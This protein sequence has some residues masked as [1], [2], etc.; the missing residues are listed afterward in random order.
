MAVQDRYLRIVW[1]D[2]N[3]NS[4]F[5]PD[6]A[7]TCWSLV[8]T[9]PWL[10]TTTPT[11]RWWVHKIRWDFCS[12]KILGGNERGLCLCRD[13][14]PAVHHPQKAHRARGPLWWGRSSVLC[15]FCHF[16]LPLCLGVH[17][18]FPGFVLSSFINIKS[19]GVGQAEK[20]ACLHHIFCWFFAQSFRSIL[21]SCESTS[22]RCWRSWRSL[23]P[24]SW[25][26]WEIPLT[27]AHCM[28]LF[29]ARWYER[30]HWLVKF[31]RPLHSKV[32]SY[33]TWQTIA[34]IL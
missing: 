19:T 10:W 20:V 18:L 27:T 9:T 26:D 15:C 28:G 32:I 29:T 30:L 1:F 25:A 17:P 3:L 5:N 13:G 8:G 14:G 7:S 31:W 24:R 23:M 16:M 12:E 4:V 22:Y 11:S 2:Q 33:W 6:G 34:F 21:I